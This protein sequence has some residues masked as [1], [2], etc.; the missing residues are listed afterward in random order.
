VEGTVD[1]LISLKDLHAQLSGQNP[2]TVIDVR[3]ECEYRAGHIAGARHI[4]ADDLEQHLAQ[5]PRDR[6][7]A[8][9]WKIRTLVRYPSQE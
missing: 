1:P 3:G 9:Y 7:V 5:I 4:P 2:P 6:P 8:T